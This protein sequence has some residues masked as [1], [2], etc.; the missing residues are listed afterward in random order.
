MRGVSVIKRD[1]QAVDIA[2]HIVCNQIEHDCVSSGHRRLETEEAARL[3]PSVVKTLL[4][5]SPALRHRNSNKAL[6]VEHMYLS[7]DWRHASNHLIRDKP[8]SAGCSSSP[9]VTVDSKVDCFTE[10]LIRRLRLEHVSTSCSPHE[11][12][13]LSRFIET[14]L[15][16]RDVCVIDSYFRCNIPNIDH[17]STAIR[18]YPAR[19]FELVYAMS[20]DNAKKGCA[21]LSLSVDVNF[22]F[23]SGLVADENE[24]LDTSSDYSAWEIRV[25]NKHHF[26][27]S[28][29]SL[30]S[31]KRGT[32]C[33]P[34]LLLATG[35][36]YARS[37]AAGSSRPS[38]E[39][40]EGSSKVG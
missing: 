14:L 1:M 37:N 36:S 39:S 10:E 12:C 9:H 35:A 2:I 26:K 23:H 19:I 15:A 8:A 24:S 25:I 32:D 29:L 34:S 40:S 16:R 18:P 3:C 13:N 28:Q 22:R 7:D 27:G 38:S 33:T 31:W 4:S 20:R 30:Y 6:G 17:R 21:I 11:I 5:E